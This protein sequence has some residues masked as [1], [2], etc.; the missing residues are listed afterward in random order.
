VKSS[1]L[2]TSLQL[3]KRGSGTG[4]VG[5][6]S[7]SMPEEIFNCTYYRLIADL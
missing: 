5:H 2:N 3:G 6:D 7:Q 4:G 1:H